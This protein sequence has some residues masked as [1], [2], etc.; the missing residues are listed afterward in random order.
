MGSGWQRAVAA[1]KATTRSFEETVKARAARDPAFRDALAAEEAQS[2]TAPRPWVKCKPDATV[3]AKKRKRQ[4]V[5]S[6]G[7]PEWLLQS[8]MMAEWN[9]LESQ[10]MEFSAVADMNA[11]KRGRWAASQAKAMGL[12]PGEPDCRLYGYP[13]RILFVEVKTTK[14]K[15]STAQDLRHDRLAALG[16]TVLVV[17]PRDEEHARSIA[18][19]IAA[20]FCDSPQGWGGL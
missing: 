6:S 15:K 18:R 2:N 12:K 20:K 1:A 5:A 11:G 10:G 4:P 3:P 7:L 8:Y 19:E 14:G 13:A 9:L 17:A 16:H